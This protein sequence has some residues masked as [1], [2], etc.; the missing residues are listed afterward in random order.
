MNGIQLF[1][2]PQNCVILEGF[3]KQKPVFEADALPEGLKGPFK[4]TPTSA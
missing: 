4:L 3:L 1:P 2:R